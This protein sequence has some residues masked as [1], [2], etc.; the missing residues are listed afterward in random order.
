MY[1]FYQV[2]G[3]PFDLPSDRFSAVFGAPDAARSSRA[4]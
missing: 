2:T 1:Q 3:S 4:R